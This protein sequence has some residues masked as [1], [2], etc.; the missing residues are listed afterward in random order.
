MMAK[1]GSSSRVTGW[2]VGQWAY[3]GGYHRW[4]ISRKERGCDILVIMHIVWE[5]CLRALLLSRCTMTMTTLIKEN[6]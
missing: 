6:I 3:W 5:E 2:T 4:D 1:K